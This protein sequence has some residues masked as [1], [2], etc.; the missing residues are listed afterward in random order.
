MKCR[1]L[2][3]KGVKKGLLLATAVFF[4][5][6]TNCVKAEG[7]LLSDFS[8]ELIFQQDITPGASIQSVCVT[9]NYIYTIENVSDD[10][11]TNDIIRAYYRNSTDENGNAVEQFSLAKTNDSQNLEHGNGMTYNPNTNEIIIAPYTNQNLE[12]RGCLF[13]MDPDSMEITGTVKVSDSYNLLSIEYDRSKDCYYAQTNSEAQ[14]SNLVLDSNFQIIEDM[15]VEDPTPGYNFQAFCLAGDYLLQSPLT[16]NVSSENYLMA[17]SINERGIAD[18]I[19]INF[20]IEGATKLEPEQISRLDDNSFILIMDAD[21]GSDYSVAY[22]YR[23]TFP[24]LPLTNSLFASS[25]TPVESTQTEESTVD[26]SENENMADTSEETVSENKEVTITRY[27]NEIVGSRP[28]DEVKES[29]F[30]PLAIFFSIAA[31]GG[32]G[33]Y[34]NVVRISRTRRKRDERIKRLRQEQHRQ[35]EQFL[36]QLQKDAS[37]EEDDDE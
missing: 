16:L 9:E 17:Y 19:S 14:Y 2:Y 27:Q 36:Q 24:N 11:V 37:D 22:F 31:A 30:S 21:Y 26:T 12:N 7:S 1:I 18:Y 13:I 20:G 33:W 34:I 32:F 29:G 8:A 3:K 10:A 4:L 25:E 15:G 28:Q 35:V 5:S 23:L 6:Q